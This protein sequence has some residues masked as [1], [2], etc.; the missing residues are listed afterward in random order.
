MVLMLQQERD[1]QKLRAEAHGKQAAELQVE[2]IRLQLE[3]ER[4]KKWY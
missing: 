3:L 4:Y 1:R 2:L